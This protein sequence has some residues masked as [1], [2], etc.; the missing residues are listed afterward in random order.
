MEANCKGCGLC[1]T[2]CPT[3]ARKL[4]LRQKK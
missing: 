2:G 1:A 4:F 3:G